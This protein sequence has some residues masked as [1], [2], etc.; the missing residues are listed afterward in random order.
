MSHSPGSSVS[1]VSAQWPAFDIDAYL[2]RLYVVM[3]GRPADPAG[4]LHFRQMVI[5]TGDATAAIE[6]MLRSEEFIRRHQIEHGS[7][8][9]RLYCCDAS[10]DAQSVIRRHAVPDLRPHPDY[11]TNFLGVLVNPDHFGTLL[12]A[13]RGTVEG[14]PIPANW[15]ADT[16]EWAAALRAVELARER[17]TIIE[18]GCGWGCWMNNTGVAARRL[19]LDVHLIGVEGDAGHIAFACEATAANKFASAQ[20]ELHR[21]IAAAT[22]GVALFPRQAQSGVSWGLEPIIGASE[23]EQA[24][25]LHRGSHDV[26]TMI[27]IADLMA[28]H[29]RIDLLHID[30]Q[31]GEGD[32]VA[33]T[34]PVLAE[35]VAYML[36]G[37]HSRTIEG[38][39]IDILV[40]AGWQLEI[41]RPA[42]VTVRP[43]G[44]SVRIDGVQGWRNPWLL[45]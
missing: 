35:R 4:L 29:R 36:I 17:F 24:D 14:V 15:H 27:P 45:P 38:R 33:R 34:L 32:L 6:C 2:N 13:L 1:E 25:A 37:T 40:A 43:E 22:A 26:L 44:L 39:L 10:F 21:G 11:L 9:E 18:L 16:A 8:H 20:V 7:D 30:I 12:Q 28:P 23:V 31:G 41:E 42:I 3:L 5:A 19:G